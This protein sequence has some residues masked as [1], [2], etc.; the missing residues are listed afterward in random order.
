MAARRVVIFLLLSQWIALSAFGQTQTTG[1]IV[2]TVRDQ[3]GAV[4]P[5]AQVVVIS[6]AT[7][8]ERKTT[9]DDGGNFAVS[10]LSPGIYQVSITTIGFKKTQFD[11]VAVAITETTQINANLPVGSVIKESVSIR[12]GPML[13]QSN[14][15]AMGRVLDARAVSELPLATRNFTSGLYKTAAK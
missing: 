4:I 10:F 13:I 14:G 3:A 12:A 2:G 9:T 5:L 1:R 6:R 8:E 15:P 11:N 7:G